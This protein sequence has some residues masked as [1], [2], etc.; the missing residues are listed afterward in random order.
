MSKATPGSR[1]EEIMA[2]TLALGI[3]GTGNIAGQFAA[4]VATARRCR[5]VGAA[6][7][8]METAAAF[9]RRHQISSAHGTYDD[10]L[11]DP[12]VQAVYISLPNSMHHEWTLRALAA[13]KHVLCEKP[14]SV[15]AAQAQEMFDAADRAKRVLME[16]FM[17]VS[18]PQTNALLTAVRT[19]IVGT[20]QIIR[21]SFCYR[22]TRIDGNIR[23]SHELAG[24][25]LMDVGCYCTSFSRLFAGA[26]PNFIAATGRIGTGNVDDLTAGTLGFPNGVVA[27]FSC[28]MGVQADNTAYLCGSEGY[29]QI[30]WPWKPQQQADWTLCRSIRPRQDAAPSTTPAQAPPQKAD[31]A[32]APEHF[33]VQAPAPLYALEADDFAAAVLDGKAPSVTRQ[34]TIGNMTVLD[35][36]RRQIGLRFDADP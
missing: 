19:G 30:P 21:T 23:F 22:T 4:G 32:P 15:T 27:T 12:A 3:M 1:P 16:A 6:S 11:T 17:Y 29:L 9:A 26:E 10:L 20:L 34:Q 28:G 24:G 7:R 35:E 18:H 13:G 5:V 36:I 31:A 14:L 33:S 25:A 2:Q 8:R